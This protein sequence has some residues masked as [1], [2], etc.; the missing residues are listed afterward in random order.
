MG[1]NDQLSGGGRAGSETRDN[2][3]LDKPYDLFGEP[4]ADKMQQ[5]DE[6]LTDLFRRSTK[7][8]SDVAAIQ[9]TSGS[10]GDVT[11]PAG[12]GS[13]NIAVFSGITGKVIADGGSTIAGVIASAVAQSIAATGVISL[14]VDITEAQFEAANTTPITLVPAQGA[15]TVIMPIATWMEVNITTDYPNNPNWTI[16]YAVAPTLNILTIW[17]MNINGGGAPVTRLQV[18]QNNNPTDR[19]FSYGTTDPRNSA[20][21]LRAQAD[22][23]AAGAATAKLHLVYRVGTTF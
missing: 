17:N 3:A 13:G 11:G 10:S 21:I 8:A 14:T 5:L 7:V 16:A 1:S 2:Y 4:S 6:M 12:A 19:L 23:N 18:G 15:G 20:L 9:N 22:P